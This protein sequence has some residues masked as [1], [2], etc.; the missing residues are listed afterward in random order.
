MV[1]EIEY[2]LDFSLCAHYKVY[3]CMMIT[4]FYN[5]YNYVLWRA[6]KVQIIIMLASGVLLPKM[7][8]MHA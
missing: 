5:K 8:G 6:W 7:Q 4:D 1:N 2:T 3:N